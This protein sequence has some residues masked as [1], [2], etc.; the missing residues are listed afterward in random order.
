MKRLAIFARAPVYGQVKTRLAKEIGK[1]A[2]LAAYRELLASTLARLGDSNEVFQAELWID[3]DSAEVGAWRERMPVRQ[4][5]QGDL[6]VRMAEAFAS[7]ASV[8]VG[9]DVPPLSAGYVASAIAA[10]ADADLVLGPVEDGGYCLIA[11]NEPHP[12]VFADIPWSTD[13]VLAETVKAASHLSVALLETLWD[14]DVAA[15]LPRWR[16]MAQARGGAPRRGEAK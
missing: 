16:A 10:L 8:V 4:Q 13:A 7:G 1:P 6:G 2:A 12:E 9:C 5:P 15:D 14:V 11:M 3:G